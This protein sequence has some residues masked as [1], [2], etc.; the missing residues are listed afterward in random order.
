MVARLE[1]DQSSHCRIA[2][3]VL[4]QI[5]HTKLVWSCG[6]HESVN[7]GPTMD[8]AHFAE[9]GS[10]VGACI[11]DAAVLLRLLLLDVSLAVG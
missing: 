11:K 3:V 9:N 1:L 6:L 4:M 7:H 2:G 8:D 5:G 10:I